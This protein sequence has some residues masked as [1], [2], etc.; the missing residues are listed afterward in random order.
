[1]KLS[2]KYVQLF[3][4]AALFGVSATAG[5]ANILFAH[6]DDDPPYVPGG[7]QLAS[8]LSAGGHTVTTRFLDAAIYNDYATFDQIF[9]YDLYAD[10]DDLLSSKVDSRTNLDRRSILSTRITSGDCLFM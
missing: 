3:V 1:M 9:V 5:A 10:N 8:M 7:D 2:K 4:A 6:V